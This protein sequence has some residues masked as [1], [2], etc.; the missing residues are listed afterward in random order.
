MRRYHIQSNGQLCNRSDQQDSRRAETEKKWT[1]RRNCFSVS[2][3]LIINGV[4]RHTQKRVAI[5]I[6]QMAARRTWKLAANERARP[7]KMTLFCHILASKSCSF[8]MPTRTGV[9]FFFFSRRACVLRAGMRASLLFRSAKPIR[10]HHK[11]NINARSP[12]RLS[13]SQSRAHWLHM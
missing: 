13:A 12:L 5:K 2:F 1:Q 9:L 6:C 4:A 7:K 3:L 11:I 10:H 8:A